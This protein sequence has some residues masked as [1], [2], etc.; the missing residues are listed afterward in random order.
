MPSYRV[1]SSSSS[2]GLAG[3]C[4]WVGQFWLVCGS[5][6]ERYWRIARSWGRFSVPGQRGVGR[7]EIASGC[8]D[9][10]R[11]WSEYVSELVGPLLAPGRRRQNTRGLHHTAAV[12][13]LCPRCVDPS[14]T[15]ND[16]SDLASQPMVEYVSR[17]GRP[18]LTLSTTFCRSSPCQGSFLVSHPHGSHPPARRSK[19]HTR[20]WMHEAQISHPYTHIRRV[21][22]STRVSQSNIGPTCLPR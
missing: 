5:F 22:G 9:L 7:L 17:S 1:I 3:L 20:T 6:E 8:S 19:Q 2:S 12:V 10:A 14:K 11:R 16:C 15:T 18:S 21:T 13:N 4:E